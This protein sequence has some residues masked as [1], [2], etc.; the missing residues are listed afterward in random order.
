MLLIVN[1]S[2][3]GLLCSL[4]R[5]RT[6]IWWNVVSMCVVATTDWLQIP[7]LGLLSIWYIFLCSWLHIYIY[8]SSFP[9]LF[10]L[11]VPLPVWNVS[12]RF[13]YFNILLGYD[14]CFVPPFFFLPLQPPL[15]PILAFTWWV[16]WQ[17]QGPELLFG[18]DDQFRSGWEKSRMFLGFNIPLGSHEAWENRNIN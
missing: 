4:C 9:F 8:I 5:F 6:I 10:C 18:N 16:W 14:D 7:A 17:W 12:N 11:D 15:L 2:K 13:D 3:S 1:T